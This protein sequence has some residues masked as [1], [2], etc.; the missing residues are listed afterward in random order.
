MTPVKS[1]W[2]PIT[3][4]P[5]ACANRSL[6]MVRLATPAAPP[7]SAVSRKLRRDIFLCLMVFSFRA[8]IEWRMFLSANRYPLRRNMR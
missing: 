2:W 6:V 8:L 3:I 1:Q 5:D 4:G 7:A